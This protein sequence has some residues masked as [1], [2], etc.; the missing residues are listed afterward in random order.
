MQTLR[1]KGKIYNS[2]GECLSEVDYEIFRDGPVDERWWG[3]ITPAEGIMLMG[4]CMIELQNGQRGTCTI[5]LRTNSSF[6]L[7]IDSFDVL[8]SGPLE[9]DVI[10]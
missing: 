9:P 7:V 8:G 4:S 6:G 1:G 10:E 2:R 5:R 3:E